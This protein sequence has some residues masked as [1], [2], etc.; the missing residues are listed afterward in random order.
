MGS[1]PDPE[2]MTSEN[3]R[4]T[5]RKTRRSSEKKGEGEQTPKIHVLCEAAEAPNEAARSEDDQ[6]KIKDFLA[7]TGA[8]G[9]GARQGTPSRQ[10][11][12][13]NRARIRGAKQRT[14]MVAFHWN[15][16]SPTGPAEQFWGGSFCRSF[17]SF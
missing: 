2:A 17:N 4:N 1:R 7:Q 15:K 11:I 13:K 3:V 16:S 10:T 12:Q 8:R 6:E 9:G 14:M 5:K